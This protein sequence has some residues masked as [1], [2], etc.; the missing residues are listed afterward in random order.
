MSASSSIDVV[1]TATCCPPL[2]PTALGR[3]EAEE[4][5]AVL[6]VLADPIR[7]R[8]LSLVATA[9]SGEVCACDLPSVVE[10]SQSTVSHHLSQLVSAGLLE[11]DQ[12]GR[13]AWFRVRGDRLA[14]ISAAL[15]PGG[16]QEDPAPQAT[17]RG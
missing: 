14:D 17:G 1:T 2:G 3:G 12:R 13:W 10:R 9:E 7:L 11:R 16:P 15:R 5:A 4:L 8:L 6:A